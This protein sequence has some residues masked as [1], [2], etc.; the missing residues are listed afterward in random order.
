ML[1]SKKNVTVHKKKLIRLGFFEAV[2]F[3]YH[4]ESL[5]MSFSL[6]DIMEMGPV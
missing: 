2:I 3:T 1:N 4:F 6:L 5:N